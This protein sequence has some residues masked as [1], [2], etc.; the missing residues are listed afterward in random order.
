MVLRTRTRAPKFSSECT[1]RWWGASGCVGL[2]LRP[3]MCL[4]AAANLLLRR[5]VVLL[6]CTA[7]RGACARRSW[8]QLCAGPPSCRMLCAVLRSPPWCRLSHAAP[9]R[10]VQ[11]LQKQAAQPSKKVIDPS[12]QAAEKKVRALAPPATGQRPTWRSEA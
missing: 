11:Q 7:L 2:L 6:P 3:R 5:T 9:H 12:V 1:A 4:R 8:R 10:Y